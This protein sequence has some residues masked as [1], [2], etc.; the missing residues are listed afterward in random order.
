MSEDNGL[1][2]RTSGR[3]RLIPVLHCATMRLGDLPL[4]P[5]LYDSG[6]FRVIDVE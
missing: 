2:N 6:Q 5:D 1:T 3:V 4:R